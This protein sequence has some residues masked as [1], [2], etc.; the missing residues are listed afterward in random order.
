MKNIFTLIMIL[1]LLVSCTEEQP[2]VQQ[3]QSKQTTTQSVQTEECNC[4]VIIKAV[5]F[6]VD[7]VTDITVKN[8]CTQELY[9]NNPVG[10]YK[11][12]DKI[13]DYKK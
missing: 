5:Y 9:R 12:G 13:C 4:G 10:N 11:I 6:P 2:E 8:D 3:V 7:N 1:L